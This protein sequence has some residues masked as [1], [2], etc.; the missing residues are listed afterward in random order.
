MAYHRKFGP[1][2]NERVAHNLTLTMRDENFVT[3][4]SQ[5]RAKLML[6]NREW[7]LVELCNATRR[8][9]WSS[10]RQIEYLRHKRLLPLADEL[11]LELAD[12]S[13]LVPQLV[14]QGL[15][16]QEQSEAIRRLDEFLTRMSGEE[17]AHLWTEEALVRD[18]A[19][20]TVRELAASALETM[21]CL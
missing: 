19:W 18:E 9:S 12:V 11:A 16:T 20:V 10:D 4:Y 6:E 3:R 14:E 17:N 5:E 7:V 8:L 2:D 13:I 15:L 1:R 21:D